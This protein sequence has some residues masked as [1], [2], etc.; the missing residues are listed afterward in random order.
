[1]YHCVARATSPQQAHAVGGDAGGEDLPGGGGPGRDA[2]DLVAQ[3]PSLAAKVMR[4]VSSTFFA[5][6]SVVHIDGATAVVSK[7][8]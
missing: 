2:A 5:R 8:A 1:M 4:I 3:D 6:G 7:I